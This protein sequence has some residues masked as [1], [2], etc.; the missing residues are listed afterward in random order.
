MPKL[1]MLI[2]LPA[3]GKSTWRSKF[4]SK[5]PDYVV[6]SSDDILDSL[7]ERDGISYSESFKKYAKEAGKE[8]KRQAKDHFENG[9]NIIWDQTNMSSKSRKLG[10]DM[11]GDDYEKEAI[12]FVIPE[13]ELKMRLA[14]REKE[15]G[16]HIPDFV[17]QNMSRS[18]QAPTKAE[19]FDKISYVRK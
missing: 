4:L 11:A 15:E 5:N 6:V 3:S 10:L 18:Y 17:I 9:R 1:I 7:A 12:V 8:M 14:K 19:G 2:G 16:K 13:P